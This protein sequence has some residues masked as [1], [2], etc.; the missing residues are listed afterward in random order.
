MVK[1]TVY[2]AA[3]DIRDYW[4]TSGNQANVKFQGYTKAQVKEL[5]KPVVALLWEIGQ[6]VACEAEVRKASKESPAE[7][8]K[9][10]LSHCRY[11]GENHPWDMEERLLLFKDLLRACG[12]KW[13]QDKIKNGV[14]IKPDYPRLSTPKSHAAA[15]AKG[16]RYLG[17]IRNETVHMVYKRR[18]VTVRYQFLKELA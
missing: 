7:Q 17:A 11:V 16:A 4:P 2:A 13:Y 1:K 15:I 14:S 12:S 18:H 10:L 5:M 9:G 8:I 6:Q 3:L